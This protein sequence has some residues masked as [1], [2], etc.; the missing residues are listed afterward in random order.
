MADSFKRTAM[1]QGQRGD[2]CRI[3]SIGFCGTAGLRA[4]DKY[5]GYAT[6]LKTADPARVAL[7]TAFE[8]VK[9]VRSAVGSFILVDELVTAAPSCS[10]QSPGII[11][12]FLLGLYQIRCPS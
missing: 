2:Y 9:P 7:T 4:V 11:R 6:I 10:P 8:T 3:L 12:G 5:L 1:L